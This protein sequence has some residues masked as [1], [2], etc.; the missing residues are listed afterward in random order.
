MLHLISQTTVN[1]T[2]FARISAGDAVLF[3]GASVTALLALGQHR[4]A[5]TELSQY[6]VCYALSS[7]LQAAN[8][9]AN[10]LTPNIQVI[11]YPEFV[12]LAVAHPLIQTWS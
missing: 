3:M 6:A 12:N 10:E 2:L 5:L 8:V 1:P 9:A 4:Q 11:D 7:D